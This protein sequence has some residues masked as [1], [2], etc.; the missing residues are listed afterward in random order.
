[1][2]L[3]VTEKN[4]AAQKIA[5]LLGV[6]K[7]KA[8]KVYSTPVYRFD[9][10]GEEWVTI[11]L[12]GHIL[13]PDF[14]PTMVYKKRGGWQGVT[15]EGET[16]PAELPASLPKPPVQKEEALHRRTAWS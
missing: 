1:M 6:K 11:G 4:D 7:P 2:K 15:E 5:D 14:A 8:D 9:V 3:V 12:R 10:D 13:E 16:L